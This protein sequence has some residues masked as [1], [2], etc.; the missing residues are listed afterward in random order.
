[1][2]TKENTSKTTITILLVLV[3]VLASTTLYYSSSLASANT[4]VNSLQKSTARLQDTNDKLEQALSIVQSQ[5]NVSA[6]S[7]NTVWIYDN[8]NRSVVT[9]QG[10]KI[11]TTLTLFGPQ[12][13]V[14]SVLGS[15]FVVAYS[16]SYY[17]VTN[18]HVVDGLVNVTATF[19]NGDAYSARV[20]G[21]DPYSDI[22]VLST[23]AAQGD[24]HSLDLVSSSS[25]LRVGQP[26][27]AI[28]DPFGL[29]GSVT[30]GIVSQLGRTI[31]YQS[32]TGTFTVVDAIQFSAPINPGNSGGPLLNAE[33]L[34]VGITSAAVTGS[35]GVGFAIPSDTILREL[36]DLVST[37]KYDLHP[38]LGFQEVDMNYQLAQAIGTNLTYGVLIEKTIPSGPADKAG[39]RGGQQTVTIDAQQYVIGGDIIVALNGTRIVNYDAFATYLERY[40]M[41]GQTVQVGITR[42]GNYMIVPVIVGVQPPQ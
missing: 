2:G 22:A 31:Q 20:V 24:L 32:D 6:A 30:F 14:E 26:V 40:C 27:V 34:V 29:S 38:Y 3:V 33:G 16:D 36:P 5:Q 10:S 1:M 39:L 19:W 25:F 21:S 37:G 12:N 18:F 28:G 41:P 17:I 13:T 11:V 42:S 9:I 35:Q 8:S 4:Q 7:L 23:H 15:G